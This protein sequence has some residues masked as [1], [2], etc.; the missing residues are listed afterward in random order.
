MLGFQPYETFQLLIETGGV[1]RTNT[2]LIAACDAYARRGKPTT[3][4]AEQFEALASRLFPIAGPQARAKGAAILGRAEALSPALEVLVIGNIGEDLIAFLEAAP[5]LSETTMLDIIARY[6]VAAAATVA[7]RAD[8]TNVVLAKL[9]QMN[10]RKV[11]RA[12]ASNT[13]IVP[14]GAYL[15]ALARSAQ[16]DHMVAEALAK[17]HDFDAA[18][19]APAF[20]DL[21]DDDR[22][23]VIRAFSNR[24][25]PVAPI[26]KTIEQI[27]VATQDLTKALMKLFAENR[28]PEVT[29]LLAQITGLDEV[30][31]GQIAHDIT[32]ASLFVI[33]RAFGCTAYEGLKVLIHA[34]AHDSERSRALADFAT[35]FGSVE[36]DA[37][38]YLMSAWRGEVNLLELVKPE[39]KPFVDNRRVPLAPAHNPVVEQ[40]IEA[41]ARIGVRRAG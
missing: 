7:R 9:F 14:R 31:C 24:Q 39:Y 11:Y 12:L 20:F 4:E 38:A 6:D 18:L 25:T 27:T 2:L 32:G 17:R 40:A 22:T 23:K 37:M 21:S 1:D 28:R 33:L 34:T 8:L 15:S 3:P 29:R 13:A 30:R 10:S 36:P 19:L 5:A 41:L 16:M 35:L 26:K